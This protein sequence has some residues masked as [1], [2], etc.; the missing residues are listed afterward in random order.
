MGKR[1]RIAAGVGERMQYIAHKYND[2]TIRF[3]LHYP[4]KL[5]PDIL[6]AA[7]AAVI[8]SVDVLHASYVSKNRTSHW[9]VHDKYAAADFFSAAEC[10]GDPMKPA[11]S[12]ALQGVHFG[13]RC[14]MQVSYVQGGE[15]CAVVVRISHLVVDGSD[16]KYLLNKLAESYRM[17]RETGSAAGLEVKNGSRSAMTPYKDLSVKELRSLIKK[18]ITGVKTEYPLAE[19]D[20][21]GTLHMLHCTIP[22]ETMAAAKRKAKQESAT[23][24]DLLLT[25]CYR[26]YARESGR[27]GEMSISSLMDLRQH[28]RNGVSEGLANMSGGLGTSLCADPAHGFSEDLRIIAAQTKAAK[29]DPLAGLAGI[30]LM[31]AA[32]KVFPVWF[33]LQVA[34]VVYSA[35]SLSLTNLGN[36]PCEPLTMDG[37]KPDAGIFGGPLKRKPSVQVGTASFDGTAE[38]TILGDFLRED[39]YSLQRF[40]DGV[41]TEI[42]H[43]LEETEMNG[44]LEFLT[45]VK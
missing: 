41:K 27:K 22:A 7:A 3:L 9:R 37:W 6:C 35:M 5:D 19:P 44:H 18:P 16:G 20:A 4:G 11:R 8:Q 28:C 42:E 17:I 30:P 26:A 34:D 10:D 43:Y 14:Q 32:T 21:H 15:S 33:L 29:E 24:N 25:A 23:V 40:L 31:H 12:I 45:I 1:N 39:T 36:I 38:L 2:T 13:D